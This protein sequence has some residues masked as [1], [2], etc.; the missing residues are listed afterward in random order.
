[1]NTQEMLNKIKE[2]PEITGAEINVSRRG[3]IDISQF[4]KT[5]DWKACKAALEALGFD[6][7][8]NCG[9]WRNE[10]AYENP[11]ANQPRHIPTAQETYDFE[12]AR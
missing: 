10:E 5:A 4:G 12:H 1:M 3:D 2:T 9:L 11:L 8:P 7:G 6:C